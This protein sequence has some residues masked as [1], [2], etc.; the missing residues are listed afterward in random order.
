[1][2]PDDMVAS[3]EMKIAVHLNVFDTRKSNIQNDSSGIGGC[4]GRGQVADGLTWLSRKLAPPLRANPK[5]CMALLCSCP[6][7]FLAFAA[8]SGARVR[9]V[10]NVPEIQ[11]GGVFGTTYQELPPQHDFEKSTLQSRAIPFLHG[12]MHAALFGLG[13]LPLVMCR[14]FHRDLFGWP[15]ASRMLPLTQM[16]FLHR[17]LGHMALGAIMLGALLGFIVMGISCL[18]AADND[19]ALKAWSAFNPDVMNDAVTGTV[20][21]VNDSKPLHFDSVPGASCADPRDNVLFLRQV[22]WI[23]WFFFL[24]L[25]VAANS[26][27]PGWLPATVKRLWWEI[28]FCAHEFGGWITV[29][30]ALCARFEVFWPLIAGWG[31]LFLDLLRERTLHTFSVEVDTSPLPPVDSSERPTTV[32]VDP[33]GGKPAAIQLLL[34]RPAGFVLSA[35]QWRHLKV[36]GIDRVW[37]PFSFASA[38]ADPAIRFYIGLRGSGWEESD[39]GV[40]EQPTKLAT[41]THKLF[42]MIRTG[43]NQNSAP[44]AIQ[45]RGPHGSPFTKCFDPK[46][47][48][49]VLIGAGTGLVSALSVLTEVIQRRGVA[50]SPGP[51]KVWFV[52]SCHDEQQLDWCWRALLTT[53]CRAREQ[54]KLDPEG[55]WSPATSNT[56]DWLG[57]T[58][59]VSQSSATKLFGHPNEADLEGA[60]V[61]KPAPLHNPLFSAKASFNV[62]GPSKAR[63]KV[64]AAQ[65]AGGSMALSAEDPI[66]ADDKI[67]ASASAAHEETEEKS[68]L[69][70]SLSARTTRYASR[71]SMRRRETKPK[72]A[73]AVRY[74]LHTSVRRPAEEMRRELCGVHCR[75][76]QVHHV[77]LGALLPSLRTPRCSGPKISPK[78]KH[79]D[80]H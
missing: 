62:D 45:I 6:T 32:F 63:T 38:S 10:D 55:A 51:K 30:A 54:G 58:I 26:K 78:P 31:I 61:R 74:V 12:I 33:N 19:V 64:S 65:K 41:W 4:N 3:L 15:I 34:D 56:I 50:R 1:M 13:L 53:L 48:A 46:H 11:K 70:R 59:H 22:V 66:G 25:T 71:A 27:P 29:H 2:D 40:W 44:I 16:E 23:V 18:A 17:L 5:F 7:I 52:W 60:A 57:V 21:R 37:H 79:P 68:V 43:T 49:A 72:I 76:R 35:G 75:R 69:N 24:P 80:Q 77:P 28:C 67:E 14:G 39:A 20:V 8:K 73:G 42:D 47:G 36:N 9:K